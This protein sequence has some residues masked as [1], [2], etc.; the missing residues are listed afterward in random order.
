MIITR[1]LL[2]LCVVLFTV[3][4]LSSGCSTNYEFDYILL[5]LQWPESFCETTKCIAHR[6]VWSIHGAWP[7]NT[8][9]SWPQDCCF[10][11]DFDVSKISSIRTELS[12]K[13]GSLKASGTSDEFWEHEWTKHGTCAMKAP[14]LKGELNYF[15][16]A[17]EAFNAL[18]VDKW[19]S[20]AGIT[21]SDSKAYPL[22]AFLSAL[23]KGLG[24][25]AHAE[26]L[27]KKHNNSPIM[28]QIN[29]CL[30]RETLKPFDCPNGMS[31]QHCGQD[32][33]AY[34]PSKQ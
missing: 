21:P 7:Q 13:W 25:K 4:D 31:D 3:Y 34:L 27:T 9:G 24:H 14:L 29:V 1:I 28:A 2:P 16:N 15:K 32:T 10:E 11:K 19:L 20:D 12:Q 33:V 30:N 17:L 6:D 18:S 5:A 23:D 8:S 26:C 22:T